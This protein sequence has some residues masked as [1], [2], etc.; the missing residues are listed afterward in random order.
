VTK[1][2]YDAATSQTYPYLLHTPRGCVRAAKVIHATNGY[3]G[4]LLPEL[5]GKLYPVRGTMSAQKSTAEFGRHGNALSW[6][7]V[8]SGSFEGTT[9]VR[10]LG[11]YYG[12][13]NPYSGDIFFGGEKANIFEVLNS[14]DTQVG[15]PCKANI[16]KVLPRLFIKGWNPGSESEAIKVWSGILGFTTDRLPLVGSLPHSI[17]KRGPEGGEYIAAGFNGYGMPLCWSSGEAIARMM[18]GTDVSDFLPDSFLAS[19]T[20]L[21]DDKRMATLPAMQSLLDGH[22]PV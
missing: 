12:C 7:I 17:T 19:E 11:L 13:Q 10:E 16:T 8:N 22:G 4:H 9:N 14:D 20:R 2:T 1:I 3:A 15:A 5:R 6:D 21:L 18:L